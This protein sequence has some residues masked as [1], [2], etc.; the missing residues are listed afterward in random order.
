[1]IDK[2]IRRR[3]LRTGGA[4]PAAPGPGLPVSSE[5]ERIQHAL[6]SANGNYT[7][8]AALLGISRTTLWRKLRA[9]EKDGESI[10]KDCGS[11]AV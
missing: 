2:E 7:K 10:T 11:G 6:S 8:A 4:G 3:T 5:A 9:M 1:M